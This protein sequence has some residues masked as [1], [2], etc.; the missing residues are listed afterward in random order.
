MSGIVDCEY[1]VI[2]G[3]IGRTT[4]Q[5]ILKNGY[6]EKKHQKESLDGYSL[7]KELSGSRVQV[8][9]NPT[10]H[11]VIVNHRGTK[12]IND[13][14]TDI[15]LMLGNKTSKRFKHSKEIT[16]K[17]IRKYQDSNVNPAVAPSDLLDKQDKNEYVIRSKLDPV[18]ILHKFKPFK[19]N[20]RTYETSP[21]T[22]NLIN[23]HNT[24]ILKNDDLEDE[25][26]R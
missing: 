22:L 4:L 14:M 10:T 12:G 24:D 17:A 16:D 19:S 18:S 3:K 23:E 6:K 9:Y 8:Y 11:H 5:N 13:V 21:T 1:K 20:E 7:D 2:G 15:N 25:I 26:G